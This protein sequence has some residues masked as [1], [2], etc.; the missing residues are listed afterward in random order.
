MPGP[1][2]KD[3]SGRRFGRLVAVRRE[4]YSRTW[5]NT[6]LC[7]CDCGHYVVVLKNNLMAGRVNSCGC[8]RSEI[9]RITMLRRHGKTTVG[10]PVPKGKE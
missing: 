1:E 5:Q 10:P 9:A 3:I 2:E 8:L 7:R 6:W 4:G